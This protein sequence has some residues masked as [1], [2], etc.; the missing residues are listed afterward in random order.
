MSFSLKS[1]LFKFEKCPVSLKS[2]LSFE[3]KKDPFG[4][5]NNL[6][7]FGN[8]ICRF[9]NKKI[10]NIYWQTEYTGSIT[11]TSKEYLFVNALYGC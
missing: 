6:A 5:E 1:A 2:T 3:K 9:K 10:E 7:F 4:E 11:S 8:L